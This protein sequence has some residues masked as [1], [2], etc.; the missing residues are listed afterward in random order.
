MTIRTSLMTHQK[1]IVDYGDPLP[2]MGVFAGY[3]VGKSLAA[4]ALIERKGWKT[5][6]IIS[7]KTAIQSTWPDQ[8][9]E[10]S[11]F[12]FVKLLGDSKQ[13]FRTLRDTMGRYHSTYHN[14]PKRPVLIILV[15]FD[16][17]K[18]IFRFLTVIKPN[19]V[20]LDESTKIKNIEALR[21][22][23]MIAY[24]KVVPNRIVMTGF[25]ITDSPTEIYSQIKFLDQGATFG[26]S[27]EA[28]LDSYF[29]K[30]NGKYILKTGAAKKIFDK[31][32]G[33]CIMI[34]ESVIK[35]PPKVYKKIALD[36]TEEQQRLLDSLSN[37]FR[38]EF[39]KV[40]YSTKS[41]YALTSK[42][43]QICDGFVTDGR[44]NLSIVDT[45]KDEAMLDTFQEIGTKEKILI[46]TNYI[47]TVK[48]IHKLLS[49][50]GYGVLTLLGETK[51]PGKI[52]K[53]F[54]NSTR[55][56][57][58]VSTLMKGNESI[59]LTNCNKAF[60]YSR[61]WSNDRYGNSQARI[62]RKGSE[63]HSSIIY[64]D[65]LLR[66][67]VEEVVHNCVAAKGNVVRDLKKFFS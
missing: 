49:Y 2:Y 4:L 32:K 33:F 60:Y 63:K 29:K 51:D 50:Y 6:V 37:Q 54:Q 59:T 16:G 40:Q 3:G 53:V 30:K 22:Q 42:A 39:G 45:P 7:T 20:I 11:D 13:K 27:Y 23:V 17:V 1:Q 62:R 65:F 36:P 9:T 43:M 25:P 61:D 58:L 55:Y 56:N 24:G 8:I 5:I 57:V 10:H 18:N 46:F 66:G 21:S 15:N 26:N 48:K 64:T 31:I 14:H 12:R 47:W 19:A 67:T 38:L 35:L 28:F 41:I 34:P 44:G 52:V